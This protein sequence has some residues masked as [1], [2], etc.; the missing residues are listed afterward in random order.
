MRDVVGLMAAMSTNPATTKF[1]TRGS[2][3]ARLAAAYRARATE[4]RRGGCDDRWARHLAGEDAPALLGL[5]D[6]AVPEM[7]FGVALRTAWLD[8]E[9]RRAE[10]SQVVL[11][12]AGFDTRAARLAR[13]GLRFFEVDHPATQS[14][15]RDALA[16][17]RGYPSDAAVLVPCDLEHE[18]FAEALVGAGFDAGERSLV[19]WEGVTP[20]LTEGAIRATVR[21]LRGLLAPGSSIVFDYV[22]PTGFDDVARAASRMGEPFLFMSH[23]IRPLLAEE[24]ISA[25]TVTSMRAICGARTGERADD[26]AFFDRWFVAHAVR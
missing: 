18:R 15:K 9:V 23:D 20:Y 21:E 7:G 11:L 22:A 17:I 2:Q 12:G 4:S 3:T 24:G 5:G 8:D 13:S 19:V 25:A 16:G 6:S 26:A 10:S 1:M 14:C